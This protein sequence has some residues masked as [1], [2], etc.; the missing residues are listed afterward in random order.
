MREECGATVPRTNPLDG[1]NLE[2]VSEEQV[3][4]L[5]AV[6]AQLVGEPVTTRC[7][8]CDFAVF[9]PVNETAGA[10]REHRCDRRPAAASVG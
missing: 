9:G 7:A 2:G 4:R 8:F 5:R 10:F 1:L 6:Y 3:A